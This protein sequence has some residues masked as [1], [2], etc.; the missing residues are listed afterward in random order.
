MKRGRFNWAHTAW[1]GERLIRP[2]AVWSNRRG[3][4]HGTWKESRAAR[5]RRAARKFEAMS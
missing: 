5:E 2:R 1:N 4:Q 3:G